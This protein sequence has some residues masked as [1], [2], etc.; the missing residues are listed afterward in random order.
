M[1]SKFTIPLPTSECRL[2]SLQPLY[3]SIQS[4]VTLNKQA[5]PIGLDVFQS[6]RTV[7]NKFGNKKTLQH[8]SSPLRRGRRRR[9]T[10]SRRRTPLS[11]LASQR[12]WPSVN[13]RTF[14]FVAGHKIIVKMAQIF[15]QMQDAFFQPLVTFVTPK[16]VYVNSSEMH[17][18]VVEVVYRWML[19]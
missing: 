8:C 10:R 6:K 7:G 9:Q 1:Y 13:S 19:V 4:H 2:S 5:L 11:T 17:P 15:F 16:K 18:L 12:P 14:D 3:I